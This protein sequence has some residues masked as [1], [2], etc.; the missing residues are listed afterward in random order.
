MLVRARTLA[1]L[2]RARLAR[3]SFGPFPGW[4]QGASAPYTA[5]QQAT[6]SR[7]SH[8]RR[9]VEVCPFSG[10]LESGELS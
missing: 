2:A 10:Q 9:S 8:Q 3:F 1:V 6:N 7:R 4:S 5:A